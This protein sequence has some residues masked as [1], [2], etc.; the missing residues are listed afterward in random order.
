MADKEKEKKKKGISLPDSSETAGSTTSYYFFVILTTLFA[1]VKYNVSDNYHTMATFCYIFAVIIG[2]FILSLNNTKTQCGTENWGMAFTSTIVPWV[3]IFGIIVTVLNIYPGWI[4]PFSNTF[5]YGFTYLV[6]SKK[7]LNQIFPPNPTIQETSDMKP[8]DITDI[9]QSLAYIY[10]D[11]SIMLNEVTV[12]NFEQ[13]WEK[14]KALRSTASKTSLILKDKFRKMIQLKTIVGE[15]VWYLLSGSLAVSIG[16][17]YSI[18]PGC[19]PTEESIKKAQAKIE[20][21]M[22]NKE[23]AV[24]KSA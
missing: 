8:T 2:E 14:T 22:I 19:P 21:R 16:Y 6:G 5:G 7:L 4:S 11:Q 17:N 15:Y 24:K 1:L 10:S 13:F 9:K 23:N 12:E 20:E 18:S 3:L